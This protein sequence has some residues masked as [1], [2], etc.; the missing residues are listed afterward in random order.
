[1]QCKL[2]LNA[3]IMYVAN[4]PAKCRCSVESLCHTLGLRNL[5]SNAKNQ[6]FQGLRCI[7]DRGGKDKM[8]GVMCASEASHRAPVTSVWTRSVATKN[9]HER[10]RSMAIILIFV[11]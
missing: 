2:A 8:P 7:L 9:R 3:K 10:A 11:C 6:M 5:T 4:V 1:M